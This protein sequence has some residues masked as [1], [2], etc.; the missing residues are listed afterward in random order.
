[1]QL[2]RGSQACYLA[3]LVLIF[4]HQYRNKKKGLT[5]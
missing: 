4:N 3:T 2:I 5:L 1:N